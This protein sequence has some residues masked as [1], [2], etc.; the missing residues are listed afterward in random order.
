MLLF[1]SCASPPI[2]CIASCHLMVTTA[3]EN[4]VYKLA[5]REIV[6]LPSATSTQL[7]EKNTRQKLCNLQ[8]SSLG[9][10]FDGK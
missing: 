4:V 5:L 3:A 9:L 8:H 6:D 2:G 10:D 1:F 7:M